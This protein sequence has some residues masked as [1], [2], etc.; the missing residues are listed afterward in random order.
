MLI[1]KNTAQD[2]YS[3]GNPSRRRSRDRIQSS[4]DKRGKTVDKKKVEEQ[5]DDFPD[6]IYDTK[7][8]GEK[9]YAQLMKDMSFETPLK[10]Q[11]KFRDIFASFGRLIKKS[12]RDFGAYLV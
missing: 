2:E 5:K 10:K 8:L 9:E 12:G 1:L 11:R 4:E 3:G 7:N 6:G